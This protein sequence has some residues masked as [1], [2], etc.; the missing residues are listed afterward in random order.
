MLLNSWMSMFICFGS[1]WSRSECT[2]RIRS[3][4][5]NN[6]IEQTVGQFAQFFPGKAF[7][8]LITGKLVPIIRFATYRRELKLFLSVF[9]CHYISIVVNAAIRL[10]IRFRVCHHKI[11]VGAYRSGTKPRCGSMGLCFKLRFKQ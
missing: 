9:K 6:S 3:T 5:T 4:Y 8:Q 1:A 2:A 7:K 11:K 10:H